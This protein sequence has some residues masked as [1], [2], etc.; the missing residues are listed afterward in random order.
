M[1]PTSCRGL[2]ATLTLTMGAMSAW[3]GTTSGSGTL[4]TD[5]RALSGFSAIAARGSLDIVVRQGEREGVQVRGDDN[6][7]PL[8]ET[9]LEGSGE[10]RT[11]RIQLKSGESIRSKL[12]LEVTVDVI[13]LNS[14]ASSGS[15][16]ILIKPL[17]TPSLTLA[18]SGSSDAR[19]EQLDAVQLSISI[20]GSGDVKAA[21]KATKLDISIAGSGAVRSRD[22]AADEVSVSIAGSGDASVTAN[23]SLA[24]SIAGSGDVEYGGTATLAKSRVAG[25][26]SIRQRP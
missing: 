19:L 16:A 9:T 5:N 11:L 10:N 4:A 23:K 24:V 7:V 12:K 26:G 15:G 8:V 17:K 3:A 18:I 6:I 1:L 14:V 21:G 25:S 22:L 2:L 20:A 13:R